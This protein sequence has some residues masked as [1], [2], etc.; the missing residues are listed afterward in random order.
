M[1]VSPR[2]VRLPLLVLVAM[3]CTV[4]CKSNQDQVAASSGQ[5]GTQDSPSDPASANMAPVS[6]DASA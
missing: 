5:N 6:T 1:S 2:F 4:G 3:V